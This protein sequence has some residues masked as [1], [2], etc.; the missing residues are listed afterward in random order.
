MRFGLFSSLIT[1]TIIIT[2]VIPAYA[3]PYSSWINHD[4]LADNPRTY[5]NDIVAANRQNNIVSTESTSS[6]SH[7][8]NREY[9][10]ESNSFYNRAAGG[11]GGVS[12]FG[13][14]GNA[15]GKKETNRRNSQAT[16]QVQSGRNH[17]QYGQRYHHDRSSVTNV[18][19]GLNCEAFVKGAAYIEATQIN[20][21]VQHHAIDAKESMNRL[22]LEHQRKN[23][24]F[25][26]LMN[27]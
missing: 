1:A 25:D 10:Q 17:Q 11:G 18:V 22:E 24:Y 13:I 8:F 5:C 6:L 14:R 7:Q 21:D 16:N 27:P 19:A 9:S 20:A 26:I 12:I 15:N 3:E 23:Y 2:S 4:A